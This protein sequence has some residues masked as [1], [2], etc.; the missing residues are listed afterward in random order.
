MKDKEKKR[1]ELMETLFPLS[2]D[3]LFEVDEEGNII[4]D[5]VDD[6]DLELVI[7]P[8]DEDDY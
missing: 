3:S 7:G 1:K 2:M 5:R 8:T 4:D 6:E